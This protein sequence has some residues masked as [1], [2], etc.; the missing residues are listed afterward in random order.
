[1][2]ILIIIM[3]F[4]FVLNLSATI[5]NIPQDYLTI[6]EGINASVNADT[7]L[8]QPGTYNENINYNGKDITIASLFITT[9][10]TI[11]I[12]QTIIDGNQNGCIVTFDEYETSLAKL[13]GFSLIE[14]SGK[15]FL[16][17]VEPGIFHSFYFGGAI[18]CANSSPELSFL[19]IYNNEANQGSGIYLKMSNSTISNVEIFNNHCIQDIYGESRGGGICCWSSNLI[20]ENIELYNNSAT[21]GSGGGIHASTSSNITIQNLSSYNNIASSGGGLFFHGSNSEITNAQ[22]FDNSTL[23]RGGGITC[24]NSCTITLTNVSI[25]DNDTGQNGGGVFCASGSNLNL[26]NT[27]ISNNTSQQYGGG[28]YCNDANIDFDFVNKSS[29]YSNSSIYGNDLYSNV[30]IIAIIDTF[31]VIEPTE[32]YAFPIDN[33]YFDIEN[34]ILEQIASDVYVSP[35]G[36]DLNSGTSWDNALKTINSALIRIQVNY[37]NPRTIF[38]DTGIFSSET[39]GEIFPLYL[40]SY[41][42]LQGMSEIETE[43]N[44]SNENN[45][46][47][48][49]QT[50]NIFIKN[51]K[52]SNGFS[53]IYSLYASPV[54]ENVHISNNNC[55]KGAGIYSNESSLICNNIVLSQNVANDG[56]GMYI[57]N[58]DL[59][60][61]NSKIIDNQAIDESGGGLYFYDSNFVIDST[62]VI[63]NY[64]STKG[65]GIHFAKSSGDL[66]NTQIKYNQSLQGGGISNRQE[67][68]IN[69]E[70]VNI[71]YNHAYCGGGL[72]HSDG[73]SQDHTYI[74]FNQEDRC[75][76]YLNQAA[77]ANDL[78]ISTFYHQIDVIVDTFTV[79]NPSS[80]HYGDDFDFTVDILH[81]KVEQINSDL[82]VSP[83]GN[84]QNIGD[85]PEN[86]LK[87]IYMASAK[88]IADESNNRTINLLPGIYSPTSNNEIFPISCADYVAYNGQSTS[89]TILDA[90]F[91]ND[92][93][94]SRRN[95]QVNISNV[96]VRNCLGAGIYSSLSHLTLNRIELSDNFNSG[97]GAG[98]VSASSSNVTLLNST[99]VNN[100]SEN[101]VGAI[102]CTWSD[103]YV[104]NT[105]LWDNGEEQIQISG[106][107]YTSAYMLITYSDIQFGESDIVIIGDSELDYEDSNID[108]DPL[109]NWN[110]YLPENSPC[111]DAGIDYFEWNSEV[112]L[113]LQPD[114][115]YGPAP[116][117]GAYE[118]GFVEADELNMISLN[119]SI[120]S[121]NYPNP[122]N[123]ETLIKFSIPE[124]S[125]VDITVYNVK[126]Q[127]VKTL[128]KKDLEKGIHEII[129]NSKDD[130]NKSVASGVYF[131]QFIVDGKTKKVKKCLLLK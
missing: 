88:I 96:K 112:L 46:I 97:Y 21:G 81:G 113:Y 95:E 7:V 42:T 74:E 36:N 94:Y 108:E 41:L 91:T 14:G 20:L 15:H 43:L 110:Y 35:N 13:I 75:N 67:S 101:S 131:Y 125:K 37:D 50:N 33:F 51:M 102:K 54:I 93:F 45:V 29:I 52:L 27:V 130:N 116:D 111:V 73:S 8:V 31:T 99:I 122:F 92:G 77:Y 103:M 70:N 124:D 23:N 4:V 105:I 121:Q 82:Y 49:N 3:S 90:E 69:L 26:I 28:I 38:L 83:V 89:E 44:A 120:I 72:Y 76:I 104:L 17:E 129:W 86:P 66:K 53:G 16:F 98:G 60:L 126:G 119:Q 30:L 71:L 1:M 114:E 65:G 19:N 39:N 100:S 57:M 68:N 107:N 34:S 47:Y 9:Q 127:K 25:S 118:Y 2:R 106:S 22:I 64:S 80:F 115:Y 32:Y 55:E 61:S 128:V 6:Q 56:G 58:S 117:I 62:Q 78:Y 11:Y 84:D 24:R 5:I 40:L 63:N 87:T 79:N 48:L 12:S 10:D 123:P 59:S 109:F 18:Y 85:D